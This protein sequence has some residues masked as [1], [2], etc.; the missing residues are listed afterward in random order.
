MASSRC[1]MP[2]RSIREAVGVGQR[3]TSE[4]K[5]V[6]EGIVT[7]QGQEWKQRVAPCSKI[8]QFTGIRNIVDLGYGS[9]TKPT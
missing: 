8:V 7:R 3:N 4:S 6:K 2:F 1:K 9:G 5:S